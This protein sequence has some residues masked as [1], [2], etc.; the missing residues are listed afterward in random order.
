MAAVG[1]A[2][3]TSDGAANQPQLAAGAICPATAVHYETRAGV[4]SGLRGIP[5]VEAEPRA[6]QLVGFLFYYSPSTSVPWGKRGKRRTRDFRIFVRGRSPDNRVNMKILWRA[7][8]AGSLVVTG[9]RR[10]QPGRFKQLLDVGPSILRV[11]QP[12]CWN[13]TL[14]MSSGSVRLTVRALSR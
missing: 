13:L 11:P 1:A 2:C 5:W 7:P 6:K 3:A 14:K 10:S 8:E 9:V 12:G 4:P